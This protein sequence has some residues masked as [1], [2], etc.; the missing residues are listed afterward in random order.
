VPFLRAYFDKAI[1]VLA[2]QNNGQ[3]RIPV[4]KRDGAG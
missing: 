3:L 2:S 1:A 4:G